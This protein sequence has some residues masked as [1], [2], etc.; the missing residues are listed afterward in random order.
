M[1]ADI[2]RYKLWNL[3]TE[4]QDEPMMD[5]DVKMNLREHEIPIFLYSKTYID[6]EIGH[7]PAAQ[8]KVDHY[9]IVSKHEQMG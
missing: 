1:E 8:F 7:G 5:N 2:D 9:I 4:S 6:G 3:P